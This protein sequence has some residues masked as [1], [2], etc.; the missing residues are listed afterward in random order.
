MGGVLLPK[1]E[2]Q[3][4]TSPPSQTSLSGVSLEQYQ[5]TQEA[6]RV[7]KRRVR[8]KNYPGARLEGELTVQPDIKTNKEKRKLEK[9]ER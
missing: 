5:Q 9:E 8:E 3:A 4:Q 7:Q 1:L 2:L 6:K